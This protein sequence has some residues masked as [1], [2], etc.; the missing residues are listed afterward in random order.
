M[1][2]FILGIILLILGLV[3]FFLPPIKSSYSEFTWHWWWAG[4]PCL[5]LGALFSILSMVR[6]ID[7]GTVAVPVTFGTTATAIE[8]GVHFLAPWTGLQEVTTRTQ[9]YTMSGNSD[10]GSK[11][12][13]DSV[14]VSGLGGSQGSADATIFYHVNERDAERLYKETKDIN[15]V[16]RAASR[17]CIRDKFGEF[18]L[19]EAANVKRDQVA[20]Q[21]G[22]CVRGAIES[23]G[24]TVES[25]QLRDVHLSKEL[26]D[27]IQLKLAA[28]QQS[29]AKDFE[30]DTARKEAI[31]VGVQNKAVSDGQ[32]IIKC[33]GKA[34]KQ[35]DGTVIIIPNTGSA[36]ENQLTPEYLQ[37]AY[38]DMMKAIVTSPNHDTVIIP[39][40]SQGSG[41]TQPLI[42][43]PTNK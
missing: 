11:A 34:Q 5:V 10:E 39:S 20:A 33:G 18:D 7:P 13:N 24:V 26:Q 27:S 8:P 30:I 12:G 15:A 6:T 9:E 28:Q 32:Q 2:L 14:P 1:A 25:F 4:V 17:T 43:V 38:I 31:K 42:Q 29:Q 3:G 16:I 41:L 35:D 40:P 23:R 36:C 21:I 22:D 37:W 19:V